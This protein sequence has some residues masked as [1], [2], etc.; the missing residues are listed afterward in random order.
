MILGKGSIILVDQDQVIADFERGF[1]R[2]WLE[3]KHPE[4]PFIP[5]NAR[6]SFYIKDDYP[7]EYHPYIEEIY[8][9]EGFY[10]SLPLIPGAVDAL[11]AMVSFGFQVFICTAPL[12][13]NPTC[14][15]E[16]LEWITEHLGVEFRR[17]TIITD[18]KTLVHGD[19]LI[20]DKVQIK[21]IRTPSWEHV[22]FA[23]HA[24]K[25]INDGRRRIRHWS[26][27]REVLLNQSL[28]N[29]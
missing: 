27:W 28:Q 29:A 26:E 6:E 8:L 9:K 16:K 17:R 12:T 5:L 22:I 15:S 1:T 20:D 11:H 21:G 7:E 10:R 19:V 2:T 14:A 4:W 24:N 13:K 18:D 23:S 25:S 3:R